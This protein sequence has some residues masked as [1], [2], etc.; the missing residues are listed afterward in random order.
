MKFKD[1]K[2]E[3][4]NGRLLTI[5]ASPY[6]TIPD[7]CPSVLVRNYE[8]GIDY[9]DTHLFEYNGFVQD[10]KDSIMVRAIKEALGVD[11]VFAFADY[12][13]DIDEI[14]GSDNVAVVWKNLMSFK[15]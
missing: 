6:C 8:P 9:S 1:I 10:A 14:N 3:L 13:S 5:E 11:K 7:N 15:N 4:G 2:K 12:T